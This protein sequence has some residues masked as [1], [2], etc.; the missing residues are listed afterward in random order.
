MSLLLHINCKGQTTWI[1]ISLL[2]LFSSD[3]CHELLGH[4]PLLAEPSFAQFS[5]EIGLAS[6]GASDEAVQKLATV[7]KGYR[8]LCATCPSFPWILP[9]WFHLV[10]ATMEEALSVVATSLSEDTQRRASNSP[11]FFLMAKLENLSSY[12]TVLKLYSISQLYKGPWLLSA[13]ISWGWTEGLGVFWIWTLGCFKLQLMDDGASQGYKGFH[14]K[15]EITFTPTLH[16]GKGAWKH[17]LL[18]FYQVASL[19]KAHC[20]AFLFPQ[21][22]FFTVEFGLCK[23]EGRLRAYGA[24]LLSSISELKVSLKSLFQLQS[25]GL[26][27][28]L[29]K[30]LLHSGNA[31][32]INL[33]AKM[34]KLLTWTDWS[35]HNLPVLRYKQSTRH[36]FPVSLQTHCKMIGFG[37]GP[38]EYYTA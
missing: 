11:L 32:H 6:L 14:I 28:K 37:L 20:V 9:Q 22:Y 10:C 8:P 18:E 5:Q 26:Q 31:F 7:S 17:L 2:F 16:L 36:R 4:V 15:G 33:S 12:W 19:S 34:V 21:C 23:Q 24:G 1:N 3:T 27:S 29:F 30:N 25:M 38:R 13:I 35:E